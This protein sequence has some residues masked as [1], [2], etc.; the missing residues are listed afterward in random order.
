MPRD[1]KARPPRRRPPLEF[2]HGVTCLSWG[3]EACM[4]VFTAL[5][6]PAGGNLA[7]CMGAS[8]MQG[9]ITPA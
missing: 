2:F 8:R 7:A 1:G 5:E 4:G 9:G 3:I 6:C